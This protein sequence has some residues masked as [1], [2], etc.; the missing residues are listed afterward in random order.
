MLEPLF[1]EK[2]HSKKSKKIIIEDQEEELSS[3]EYEKNKSD[4]LSNNRK[5]SCPIPP[6]KPKNKNHKNLSQKSPPHK[7]FSE[8]EKNIQSKQIKIYTSI[9]DKTER[10]SSK[11]RKIL[12]K[13]Y[14]YPPIQPSSFSESEENLGKAP[15]IKRKRDLNISSEDSQQSR[16]KKKK[17]NQKDFSPKPESLESNKNKKN[18]NKINKK[19][20][21]SKI[22][23]SVLPKKKG[24]FLCGDKAEK[25]VSCHIEEEEINCNIQWKER[26]DGTTPTNSY[27]SN[28]LIKE[29]DPI[30]LINFYESNIRLTKKK[31]NA[32]KKS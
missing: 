7:I 14:E 1:K 18:I 2:K 30:L 22:S 21:I 25:I 29:Y 23:N 20:I 13:K 19:P 6:Q 8:I 16:H 26:K 4:S 9:Q 28:T 27:F 12:S 32:E 10:I 31:K 5:E 15:S 3:F 17:F 11:G 24:S